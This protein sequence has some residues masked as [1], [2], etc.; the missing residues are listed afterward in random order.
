[1]VDGDPIF[2][3]TQRLK[4]RDFVPEDQVVF[5]ALPLARE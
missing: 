3:R 2:L 4:L 1:M 5:C